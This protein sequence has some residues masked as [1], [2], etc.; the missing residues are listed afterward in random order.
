M[1]GEAG[2]KGGYPDSP[3]P[4]PARSWSL[5]GPAGELREAWGTWLS[6]F[7]WDWYCTMTFRYQV[8]PEQAAK[9]WARWVRRLE[10]KTRQAVR[11]A[12]ALEYQKRGVIH[13]HALIYFGPQGVIFGDPG[14]R[15]LTWMDRWQ[16]IGDGYARIVRYDPQR[17]A[18]FY[19]GKYVAKGGE[20]DI[21]GPW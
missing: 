15:R 3:L 12:R 2:E 5:L 19:L 21:G 10:K 13:Y 1:T 7:R 8:H 6:G 20:V 16:E 17:G 4:R 14:P 18:G 11:W 9:R